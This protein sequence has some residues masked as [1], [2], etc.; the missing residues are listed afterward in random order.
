M[1][2]PRS[3]ESRVYNLALGQVIRALREQQQ[4]SQ[5]ELASICGLTQSTF[6]RIEAGSSLPDPQTYR[7]LAERLGYTGD[8]LN[9]LVQNVMGYA[10]KGALGMFGK[11]KKKDTPWWQDPFSLGALALGGLIAAAI[12]VVL[13]KE[14]DTE[15]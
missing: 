8:Q 14:K 13:S 1:P 6:S 12:A 2:A 9:A 11:P 10:Q 3:D 7:R 15:S 4:L 5:S